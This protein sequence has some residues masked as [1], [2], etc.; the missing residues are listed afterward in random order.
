MT[1]SAS[2]ENIWSWTYLIRCSNVSACTVFQIR[3]TETTSFLFWIH[4]CNSTIVSVVWVVHVR[5]KEMMA[6]MF[7]WMFASYALSFNKVVT[8]IYISLEVSCC[9]NTFLLLTWCLGCFLS[10]KTIVCY[11]NLHQINLRFGNRQINKCLVSHFWHWG[12]PPNVLSSLSWCTSRL[13]PKQTP[14]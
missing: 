11:P 1:L 9:P 7:N 5:K 12:M 6:V 2:R 13:S 3:L 8:W 4:N 10:W 14:I